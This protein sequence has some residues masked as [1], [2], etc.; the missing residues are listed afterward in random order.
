[1]SNGAAVGTT[2]PGTAGLRI[3]TTTR[4]ATG[5]PTSAFGSPSLQLTMSAD[6]DLL[7]RT[8]SCLCDCRAKTVYPAGVGSG[9]DVRA[10]TP[11]G[12]YTESLLFMLTM[13]ILQTAL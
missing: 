1:M 2:P 8:E 7:T 9:T 4:P 13:L 11:A 6:A 3:G 10:K 5:T 12:F